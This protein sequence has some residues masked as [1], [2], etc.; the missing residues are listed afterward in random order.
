MWNVVHKLVL[1]R[2]QY[3]EVVGVSW[4]GTCD[5]YMAGELAVNICSKVGVSQCSTMDVCMRGAWY[6]SWLQDLLRIW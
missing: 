1:Q 5:L 2:E 4:R 6:M 3:A